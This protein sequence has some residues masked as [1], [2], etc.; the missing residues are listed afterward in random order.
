MMRQTAAFPMFGAGFPAPPG[1]STAGDVMGVPVFPP[2]GDN[3]MMMAM[4]GASM[5]PHVLEAMNAMAQQQQLQQQHDQIQAPVGDKLPAA[6]AAA[7]AAA[8]EVKVEPPVA[9]APS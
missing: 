6:A 3:P 9:A 8:A 5:P 4:M 2:V 7:A 1:A